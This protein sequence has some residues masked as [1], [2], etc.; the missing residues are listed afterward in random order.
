MPTQFEPPKSASDQEFQYMAIGMV[1]G[2]VPG[3]V[4]GLLLSLALG[5][6][7][8]WVSVVGGAGII[9]GLVSA[10]LLFRRKKK[11]GR[12]AAETRSRD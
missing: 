5:N 9:I 11:S 7:A 8:M 2:A 4:I 1:S 3:I 6:P 12:L 10:T